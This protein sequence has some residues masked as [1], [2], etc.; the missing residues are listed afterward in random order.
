MKV[1]NIKRRCVV[2]GKKLTIKLNDNRTYIGGQFFGK[3]K[4]PTGKAKWK[5]VGTS[6]ILKPI[7]K[8][9]DIVKWI[10]KEKTVEYWECNNCY[11]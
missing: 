2:C 8:R 9:T 1:R 6:T 3:I 7:Q 5:K 11:K 4:I 10:G